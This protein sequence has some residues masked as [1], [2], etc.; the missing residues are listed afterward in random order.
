MSGLLLLTLLVA[1]V[2]F[3]RVGVMVERTLLRQLGL[4][5]LCTKE[6][7]S[8][9]LLLSVQVFRMWC[10]MLLVPWK[11]TLFSFTRCLVFARLRTMCELTEEEIPSVM[12]ALMPDPTR[13]AMM[14]VE[15]CR[16]VRMRRT[17]VVCVSRVTCMTE[18]LMLPL[19]ITTR[20]SSLLT[21]TMRQGTGPGGPL[22][23][24]N[25]LLLITPPQIPM[26]CV[27]VCLNIPRWWL[28]LAMVYRRVSVVR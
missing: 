21:M 11:S 16:A 9:T 22:T 2:S 10:S 20:L 12:C 1:V 18:V 4:C 25:P 28:T 7:M 26:L 8:L 13:F 6:I 14:L 17:F 24:V 27:L 23:L 3:G 15:G 19:V 5:R